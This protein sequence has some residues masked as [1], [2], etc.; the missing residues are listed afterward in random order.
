MSRRFGAPHGLLAGM[1]LVAS[2]LGLHWL[3][4]AAYSHLLAP[5]RE[6]VDYM[7]YA[8]RTGTPFVTVVGP[9]LAFLLARRA[10]AASGRPWRATGLCFGSFVALDLGILAVAGQL[11]FASHPA[12][13][14]AL[15]AVG[16]GTA[17][18][19]LTTPIDTEVSGFI[20]RPPAA[21][22][23]YLHR[24]ELL[25]LWLAG[26]Q[27]AEPLGDGDLVVGARSR[28]RF[29]ERGRPVEMETEIVELDPGRKLGVRVASPIGSMT[30]RYSLEPREGGTLL[31][32][33][34]SAAP[35]GGWRLV[36][37]L[38]SRGIERRQAEDLNRL[39]RAAEAGEE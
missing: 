23:P 29:V 7:D 37:A 12:H 5:G 20:R 13:L 34:G 2:L 6:R 9:L 35:R 8:Q 25:R 11:A 1:A 28:D 30:M 17:L 3:L 19:G 24:P 27:G 16:L 33:T 14:A 15:G 32:I 31:S 4:V 18:G 21:L 39:R 10:T 22:F 38:V 26:F 36:A